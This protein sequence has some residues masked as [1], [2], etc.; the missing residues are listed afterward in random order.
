MQVYNYITIT[1][2]P[3]YNAQSTVPAIKYT[4]SLEA[5]NNVT[6]KGKNLNFEVKNFFDEYNNSY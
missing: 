6:G 4:N 1:I 2:L 3:Y 5:Q